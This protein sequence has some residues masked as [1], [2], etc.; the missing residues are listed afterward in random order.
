MR[1]LF[2]ALLLVTGCGD[3]DKNVD[4]SSPDTSD[5]PAACQG[6][7]TIADIQQGGF[8]DGDG[9]TVAC[10]VVTAELTPGGDGFFL[11]DPN[12]GAWSGIY[13]YL[14]G[15][16]DPEDMDIQVGDLVTVAGTISEWNDLTEISIA[17]AYDVAKLGTWDVTVDA[18]DCGTTDWEPWEG[19]LI[20]VDG[21][22]MTSW[23]DNYGEVTT[24]C[25]ITIDDMYGSYNGGTG[26]VCTPIVAPLTYT[27]EA[28]K[29]VPRDTDDV[30]GCTGPDM[31]DPTSI[32][33][34]R[35]GN[36]ADGDH[37]IVQNVVITTTTTDDGKMFFVQDEGGGPY[38][39]MP[40][41][42]ATMTYSAVPG[43]VVDIQGSLDDYY[44]MWELKPDTITDSGTTT[45]PVAV[46]L[47]STPADWEPYEGAL[48][49]LEEVEI[50]GD[51]D[52]YG[53]VTT[54]YGITINDLFYQAN[55]SEGD[56]LSSVTGVIEYSYDAF[57]IEPRDA[58]D[59]VE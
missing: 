1:H 23:P 52:T 57:K 9:V 42:L 31:G 43:T 8:A 22:E 58:P 14:Y 44:G 35:Q 6:G 13:V 50:T 39:G 15:G 26:S 45:D 21:L 40:I 54:N 47:S 33:D 24:S 59:L 49:T 41:Y 37:V 34:L 53:E 5:L 46:T 27:Y 7:T 12:G 3:D 17:T 18:V 4:D 32:A 38:T 48:V 25:G 51:P 2:L 30:A 10:A 56:H 16:M 55:L 19:C 11:Q 36:P 28:Y 29:L 20:S